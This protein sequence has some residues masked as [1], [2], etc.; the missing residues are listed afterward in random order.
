VDRTSVEIFANRGQVYMPIGVL[1]DPAQRS[2][3]V[4]SKGGKARLEALDV[5]PLRSAW[6]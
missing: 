1:L 6:R 5:Y 3:H 2:V 4:L